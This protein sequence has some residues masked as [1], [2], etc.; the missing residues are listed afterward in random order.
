MTLNPF[1]KP[2]FHLP[3]IARGFKIATGFFVL[4]T[5]TIFII[6]ICYNKKMNDQVVSKF[7]TGI[8]Q[9]LMM[10]KQNGDE[11]AQNE[12]LKKYIQQK[13][14]YR[15]LGLL[16]EESRKRGITAGL[17]T[18]ENG[19]VITRIRTIS[20]RGDN[21]FLNTPQ[22]RALVRGEH[23]AS[24]EKGSIDPS[25]VI[26]V[27][28]RPITNQQKLIGSLINAHTLDNT[29]AAN[30]KT[31]YLPLKSE[32]VFFTKDYGIYGS[33]FTSEQDNNLLRSYF[34]NESDWIKKVKPDEVIEF[35]DGRH[36]KVHQ[37]FLK[38][39][40]KDTTGALIFIP[41]YSFNV[42]S[43]S[44]ALIATLLFFCFAVISHIVHK[45]QETRAY[46]FYWITALISIFIFCGI[47]IIFKISINYHQRLRALPYVIYNSTLRLQPDSGTFSTE[48]EQK[49]SIIIDSGGEPI[50]TIET[51]LSFDP[52]KLTVEEVLM[53]NSIC[54][55]VVKKI[56]NP[57]EGTVS[58]SCIIPDP[59]FSKKTGVIGELL[60]R[61]KQSGS[62]S[63]KFLPTTKILAND[64]IATS[65]LRMVTNGSYRA[66]DEA[67]NT[68]LSLSSPTHP[69]TE[70]WYNEKDIT[71]LWKGPTEINY[72]LKSKDGLVITEGTTRK[73]NF[74]IT[75]PKDG[76]YVFWAQANQKDITSMEMPQEY[77]LNIDSTSPEQIALNASEERVHKNDVVRFVSSGSDSTSGLQD[78]YYLK[79]NDGFLLPVGK[80]VFI[81]FTKKGTNTVTLRIF[82]NAG[83]TTETKKIIYVVD[84][85]LFRR[86]FK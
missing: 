42:F 28:G 81:P 40:E 63:L 37:L 16:S 41:K 55:Y 49:I 20:K 7:N 46:H 17:V 50:N 54:G 80:Q 64:G 66:V 31:N 85:S 76:T 58:L 32:V 79:I 14:I 73:N 33:S 9:E 67:K 57:E 1:K 72:Q 38:G 15:A 36:Y 60:I 22:G 69:N 24:F 47:I 83:N 25:N 8:N 77:M 4:A 82:D 45:N 71:I 68:S 12:T 21:V 43:F 30:F 78:N 86:L 23:P 3:S 62:F 44:I 84:D 53:E 34:S 10:L 51:V 6:Q 13:D 52:S 2:V 61:P 59:G 29:Y 18:D 39:L 70:R 5:I 35:S 75:V 26:M 48:Y 19:I 11:I 56:I 27:T 65:V 74:N